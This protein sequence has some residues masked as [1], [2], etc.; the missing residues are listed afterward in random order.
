MDAPHPA[1]ILRRTFVDLDAAVLRVVEAT[2]RIDRSDPGLVDFLA[3]LDKILRATERLRALAQT[4]KA[5]LTKAIATASISEDELSRARHDL[6][7]QV[8]PMKGYG[9]LVAEELRDDPSRHDRTT[10][11]QLD[12]IVE[13]ADGILPVIDRL[14]Y[15]DLEVARASMP[16]DSIAP[17]LMVNAREA[18][19]LRY[20][21]RFKG[22]RVLIID[23]SEFNR[24]LL[25][26]QLTKAGLEV[27]TATGGRE[28]LSLVGHEPVDLILCDIMMPVMNGHEV[29]RELKRADH[30]RDI[31]V[32]MISALAE[33][34][35]IVS[36][37]EAGADDYLSTPFNATILHA[38]IK[39]CLDKKILA[40]ND[41]EHV[42]QLKDAR[43]EMEMAIQAMDDGFAVFDRDRRL[44]L[45]NK[46]FR[47]LYPAVG[48]LGGGGFTFEELLVANY[49]AGVYFTERRLSGSRPPEE[50][51]GDWKGPRLARFESTQA[52]ME[53]LRD[54]RWIEIQN[55]RTPSGGTVSV[56][57]DVT[58]MKQDEERL[59]FLALHDP[60]TGLANRT[61]F[62]ARLRE[63]V[64]KAKGDSEGFSLMYLDLDGFKQVNDT[65]G[66]EF[67]DDL[68]IRV[69]KELEANTRDADLVARL[70]GDEFAVI[71]D[72]ESDKEKV[73]A[74][75]RRI[76]EAIGERIEGEGRAVE[77]G[78]SVGVAVYPD[79]GES[80]EVFLGNADTAMYAAKRAG[81]GQHRFYADL[82]EEEKKRA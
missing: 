37:L 41:R 39:G 30:S 4:E 44:T 61:K 74:V 16:M 18:E 20:E 66:H 36:C 55:N 8:N 80:E 9:E 67:G 14:Q 26:R 57:K 58:A 76:I 11:A 70:G 22:R 17:G 54:G 75:S 42:G 6:R 56:H 72:K 50:R 48:L 34:K 64:A 65:L 77:F 51:L 43:A 59:T 28:G 73:S 45:C 21:G 68:L 2:R 82:S 38:R 35:S 3:D 62:E 63:A 12:A 31:P 53:R 15:V 5:T 81:K 79:D 47:E 27:L 33:T 1:E 7:A 71:L 40:D 32:L 25:S 52:H 24:D 46:K 23:D 13:A 29:L 10:E 78:V 60:L 69:G 49:H 19:G